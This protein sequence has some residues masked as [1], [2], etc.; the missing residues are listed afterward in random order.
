MYSPSR[1]ALHAY[2]PAVQLH[3]FLHQR[4]SYARSFVRPAK[5][6]FHSM[7]TMENSRQILLGNARTRIGDLHED[8]IARSRKGKSNRALKGKLERV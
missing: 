4:Q 7:E 2:I 5:C 1:P 3:E 8:A 6:P